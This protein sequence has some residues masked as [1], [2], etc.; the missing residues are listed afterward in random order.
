MD[1]PLH[2]LCFLFAI[3]TE[4]T[5]GGKPKDDDDVE[6]EGEESSCT[7]NRAT[8]RFSRI[9]FFEIFLFALFFSRV[10]NSS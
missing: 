8:S 2:R 10:E 3:L 7:K 5:F 1:A 6:L 4:R 9:F